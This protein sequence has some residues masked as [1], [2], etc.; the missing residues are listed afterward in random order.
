MSYRKRHIKHNLHRAVPKQPLVTRPW[1]WLSLLAVVLLGAVGYVVVF[2]PGFQ[3]KDVA[4]KGATTIDEEY[5]RQI[6]QADVDRGL[7]SIA[8]ITSK[9]ILLFNPARVAKEIKGDQAISGTIET[10]TVQKRFPRGLE[11]TVTERLPAA[12][13]CQAEACWAIDS[14]GVIFTDSAAHAGFIVR[15]S[16]VIEGLADGATVLEPATMQQLLAIADRLQA[17]GVQVSS[18]LLQKPNQL[19][20]GTAEG[21]NMY[22]DLN[23]REN[24]DF[25]LEKAV[26]LLNK[27]LTPDKRE[28]LKYVDL[29]FK[30]RAFFR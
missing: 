17:S 1:F 28:G 24:P 27:E 3:I 23:S 11:V 25:Q 8:G 12:Q 5:L 7:F 2:Y 4:I 18:M 14:K 26:L 13:F 19:D 15:Q 6:S 21:W 9:S 22:F 29:R 16:D 30:D 20:V 10:V